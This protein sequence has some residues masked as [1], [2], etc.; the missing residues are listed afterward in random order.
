MLN[1][2]DSNMM[3]HTLRS[4]NFSCIFSFFVVLLTELTIVSMVDSLVRLER[5]RG[6]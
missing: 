6:L 4:F 5:Q 3:A 1:L 2:C